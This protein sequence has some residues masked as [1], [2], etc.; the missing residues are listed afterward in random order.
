MKMITMSAML[1]I[2]ALTLVGAAQ[3]EDNQLKNTMV[4]LARLSEALEKNYNPKGQSGRTVQGQDVYVSGAGDFVRLF[5]TNFRGTGVG[6]RAADKYFKARDA[7]RNLNKQLD[8]LVANADGTA[9]ADDGN[10]PLDD[11]YAQQY[12]GTVAGQWDTRYEMP[13]EHAP[14]FPLAQAACTRLL[15]VTKNALLG[16]RNAVRDQ[17][18]EDAKKIITEAETNYLLAGK[19]KDAMRPDDRLILNYYR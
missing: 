10:L 5:V 16:F 14:N 2:G 6:A 18:G 7:F 12:K 17:G 19:N 1:L 4:E 15:G 11:Q 8:L 3:A 13:T 9:G